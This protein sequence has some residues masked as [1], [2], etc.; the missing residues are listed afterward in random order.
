MTTTIDGDD[1][2]E[3][4]SIYIVKKKQ[5]QQQQKTKFKFPPEKNIYYIYF[6]L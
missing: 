1:V 6:Y 2:I 5:Q 4:K 3:K